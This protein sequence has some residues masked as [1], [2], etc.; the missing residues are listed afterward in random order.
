M[1]FFCCKYILLL[2]PSVSDTSETPNLEWLG[3]YEINNEFLANELD[4]GR[5][6][7][8]KFTNET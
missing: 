8:I 3:A 5:F 7:L 1:L 2:P 4:L 6:F